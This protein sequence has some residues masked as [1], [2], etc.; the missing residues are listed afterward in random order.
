MKTI[1]GF[2]VVDLEVQKMGLEDRIKRL[3]GDLKLP[4][5]PILD[6]QAGQISQQIIF[7]RLLDVERSNLIKVN[8]ELEKKKQQTYTLQR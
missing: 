8:F 3:E 6:E 1:E 7:R 5:L 4:L 2:T